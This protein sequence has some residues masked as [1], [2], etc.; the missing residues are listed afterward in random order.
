MKL[1]LTIIFLLPGFLV[2]LV[3][4]LLTFNDTAQ[5]IVFGG[6]PDWRDLVPYYLVTG[7]LVIVGG[8]SSL[9][10][11]LGDRRNS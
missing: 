5:Y 10:V 3:S 2:L 9:V 8:V 1:F 4:L 7:I 11:H 6:I